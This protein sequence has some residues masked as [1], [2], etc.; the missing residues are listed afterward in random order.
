MPT[1]DQS[2]VVIRFRRLRQGHGVEN[3]VAESGRP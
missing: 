3:Q 1:N 2:K